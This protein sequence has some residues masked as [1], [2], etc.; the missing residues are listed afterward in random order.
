MLWDFPSI[1]E[2]NVWCYGERESRSWNHIDSNFASKARV[3]CIRYILVF[4]IS[5]LVCPP[6]S[7]DGNDNRSQVFMVKQFG[8]ERGHECERWSPSI[9]WKMEPNTRIIA[10]KSSIFSIFNKEK[11]VKIICNHLHSLSYQDGIV[12]IWKRKVIKICYKKRRPSLWQFLSYSHHA[13][14]VIFSII[15]KFNI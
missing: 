4:K 12:V 9:N 10:Y 13:T 11:V 7:M 14:S 3:S 6:K 2:G 8:L 5:A 15:S 1:F